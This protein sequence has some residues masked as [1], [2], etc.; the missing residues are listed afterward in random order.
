MTLI[1]DFIKIIIMETYI[2]NKNINE[3]ILKSTYYCCKNIIFKKSG[4]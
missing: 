2:Y 4:E 1:K 3:D